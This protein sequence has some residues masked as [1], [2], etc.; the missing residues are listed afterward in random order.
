MLL[1]LTW[2]N[3]SKLRLCLYWN[4]IIKVIVKDKV[5]SFRWFSS[6]QWL[7]TF[8][9]HYHHL[10]KLLK[11]N[12]YVGVQKVLLNWENNPG[13]NHLKNFSIN[14]QFLGQAGAL[15]AQEH[16][17]HSRIRLPGFKSWFIT[18]WSGSF[19]LLSFNFLIRKIEKDMYPCHKAV[20]E[21]IELIENTEQSLV[22][23]K[24]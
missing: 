3:S 11:I 13:V 18:V 2:H 23:D 19:T 7:F 12:W 1:N 14:D 8:I 22:Y 17:P 24:W 5:S 4:K 16:R 9:T 15:L 10:R 20:W 21:W 6:Q